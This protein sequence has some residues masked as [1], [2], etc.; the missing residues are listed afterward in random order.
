M[1]PTFADRIV[2]VTGSGRGIGRGLALHFAA[3]GADVIVNFFR[4][5]EPA[6]ATAREIE[7]MGRRALVVKADAG[8]VNDLNRMFDEIQS[9]FGALDVLVHCAASGYNR[10]AMA[11]KPRGWDWTMNINARALLFAAQRAVPLMEKRGG[12]YII[13]LTSPGS[14][15][16][17]PDYVAVGAS[18]AAL[19]SLTRYLGVELISKNINVNAVSPGVVDTEALR[20][21]SAAGGKPGI[22]QK[23]TK[24]VPAGRL[25]TPEDVAGVVAFLCTPAAHMIVGQTIVV[26][27]GFT[28]PVPH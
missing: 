16:V 5:R 27:G 22:L 17:V 2:L 12:G 10:P 8:N 13:S 4:N 6:E 18:K 9:S 25:I 1:N 20:H 21:F 28:L 11:Q 26:D 15:R 14:T 7:Q 19:E 24:D 23:F 3:R